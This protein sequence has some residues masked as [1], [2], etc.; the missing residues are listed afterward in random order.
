MFANLRSVVSILSCQTRGSAAHLARASRSSTRALATTAVSK[1]SVIQP[2][3]LRVQDAR[4]PGWKFLLNATQ[5]YG[6]T[7]ENP[8]KTAPEDIWAAREK[9]IVKHLPTPNNAYSG[10]SVFV[11][12]KDV[13]T[14]LAKLRA[15]LTI[16]AV[17]QT[18]LRDERHEKKGE[19][20][21]RLRSMRWRRRFAHEVRK[22]VQLVN[23][24]RARGA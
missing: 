18:N 10:R 8:T 7:T 16:N 13:P 1:S 15:I 22:K 9:S 14:A 19:K 21:N 6:N 17:R 2:P 11:T 12:D 5:N 3:W 23:E 24:I 20:R 4:G